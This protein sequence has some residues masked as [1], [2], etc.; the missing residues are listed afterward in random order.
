MSLGVFHANT[1]LL[2]AKNSVGDVAELKNIALQA[3]DGEVLVHSADESGLWLEDD[4]IVGVVGNRAAGG[5]RGEA[6]VAAAAELVVH[7]VV[8][9]QCSMSASPGGE[10]VGEHTDHFIEFRTFERAIRIGTPEEIEQL[11]LIP[12]ARGHFRDNLLGEYIERLLGNP[13]AVEFAAAHGIQQRGAFDEIV[14]RKREEPSFRGATHG[15]AGTAHPLQKG[16]DRAWRP[17]LT[18]E[19]D[20][21]DV[22]AQL[23]GR[24]RDERFQLPVLEAALGI[25]A[26]FLRHAAMVCGNQLCADTLGQVARDALSVSAGVDEDEG[27]AMLRHQFG[28]SIV[29][30]CP[31]FARHH[32]FERCWRNLDL[33]LPLADMAGV[34]DGAV[35]PSVGARLPRADEESRHLLDGFLSGG[36]TN[37]RQFPSG[38]RTGR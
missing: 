10:P 38:Q 15:V 19:I 28:Q 20:V 27:G 3:L 14:T 11:L 25:E 9:D 13:Q 26:Q 37:T 6:G 31:D 12:L 30:Q 22:D 7:G 23:Q 36:Q 33:Q 29:N 16:R 8:I 34:D 4:L 1:A 2:D 17:D 24:R 5:E 32:R 35:G 18:H 21:A